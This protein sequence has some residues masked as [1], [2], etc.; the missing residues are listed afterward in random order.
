MMTELFVA[1][2][3]FKRA[4][5]ILLILVLSATETAFGGIA[6]DAIR[7]T[8]RSSSATNII[9]PVLS[10]TSRNE[11]LLAFISMDA[12]VAGASVT[13]VTGANL[14]WVLVRRT[15][16]QLGSAEIWRAFAPSFVTNSSI[17][18]NL[19]QNV[20]ASMTVVTFTGVDIT[21]TNGSGAIGTT[22]G[23]SASSG[24]P[25]ASLTTTR[26]GSWVF[27]VGN[28]WDNAIS[29]IAGA[30]QVVLHQYLATIGDTYWVQQ[31][32]APTPFSG[33]PVFI[34]DISPVTDRYNLS[35]VEIL[36]S[37]V[38]GGGNFSV[39]GSV[40]PTG[41]GSGSK[42]TL[43]Q[44]GTTVSTVTVDGLGN[45]VFTGLANGT[46]TVTPSKSGDTF[47]PA[48][49]PAIV[50]GSN[51]LGI[52]FTVQAPPPTANYPDLSDI[53][54][55]NQISIA[56]SGTN[57]QL[58]YTHDTFNGGSGPLEI[59]PV[60]NSAAG[61]YQGFQHVYLFQSGSWTLVRTIPVAGAFEFDAVHGHFHFP[62]ASYGLYTVNPDGSLGTP[63]VLAPKV[64]FCIGDSFIYDSTLPNAGA[65]GN[66]G[67]CTD[68]TSLRGLSIG[69]V[70][71]YDQTDAGQSIPLGNLPN[72]TYWLRAI[73]DP[74]NYLAE[75]DK[76]NNETDVK[77]AISG[78]S[79]TVL[80]T[81][82]PV[83]FVPP[84]I[85]LTS[86]AA[87]TVSGT[88]QLSATTST[89]GA[90][91]AQYLVDGISF[92][93]VIPNPP[94][95]LPWDT[96]TLPNGSH[97]LAVQTTGSGGRI[98]TSAVVLVTVN[99][100]N[101]IPPVVNLT[102]PLVGSTVSAVTPII[103][104]VT[105]QSGSAQV[106][107][108]VDNV[109]LGTA[110]T[111]PPFMVEWNT[112]TATKG[113]HTVSA[114]ATDGSGLVGNSGPVSVTVDNTHPAIPLVI[115]SN[116]SVDGSGPMQ[117]PLFSTTTAR[118]VVAFVAY[119]GPTIGGQ[120][121]T[122]SGAGLQWQLL[123]RSDSQL[124]TAEIWAAYP[125]GRLTS[126]RVTS[127]PG[128]GSYHGSMT[129][130]AFTNASGPGTVGQASAPSGPPD[131]FLPGVFAGSWVFAVGNDWDRAVSR[132]PVSG[133]VLVHQRVDTQVGDTYWVQSTTA[134]A[135]GDGLVDIHDSAPTT[136]QWNYAA[137]EIVATRQ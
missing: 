48:S 22:V 108:Y 126:V 110:M 123:K 77:L 9:T 6:I 41:D 81:V 116:V 124:G 133:Q 51:A 83:Q 135:T 38:S 26:N 36:A 130:I 72:G 115:D 44:S 16:A 80:A 1:P 93:N 99:N 45:Y 119:D 129:V 61:N 28:D 31:Q 34:N 25:S 122:V 103:A 70:D 112:L 58:Q 111:A 11:L 114:S 66:L 78:T 50:S 2:R 92:G 118:L 46:Y 94:Y 56:G 128:I 19:S 8:D 90:S 88:V 42:M 75:S 60:Y 49:Q 106:Q 10:T 120:T 85:T 30:N 132:V 84:V 32:I 104:T 57:R 105:V 117:S 121:A 74:F 64:G 33:S 20:A 52:N 37:A 47:T 55:P 40:T 7:S 136:D 3:L 96:T 113:V 23:V 137:V 17:Q 39:S 98:G 91:G 14:T 63:I 67:A 13:S 68:P 43:T 127:Q 101:T 29:R 24:A 82:S 134:P 59:L 89:P 73:V 18:A 76:T 109:P 71:E 125:T 97:W 102:D 62:F 15:N 107:F 5:Q 79:V 21:G 54:P 12:K 35:I 53:I 87:G 86:P 27:G 69:A 4:V 95:S 100:V 65:F 131:I